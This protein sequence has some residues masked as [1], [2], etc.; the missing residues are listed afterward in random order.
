MTARAA[1]ASSALTGAALP[2]ARMTLFL[3]VMFALGPRLVRFV[4][5]RT[6]ASSDSHST[7][8]TAL[9]VAFLFAFCA[10]YM[11]GM[12][13]ITG[14]YLAGV[15]VAGT[16]SR[17]IIVEPLRSMCNAFF[18]PVFFVSIG[19]QVDA[20]DLGSHVGFFV[21]LLTVAIAGKV[22]GCA[23][24]ALA[25]GFGKRNSMIVGVG[26]IPR[27]EVGLITAS[28]GFAAGLISRG[29]YVQVV[30]LVLATTLITPALLRVAFA[31]PEIS[32]EPALVSLTPESATQEEFVS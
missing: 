10:A 28:L 26:M 6:E 11:G 29:N 5:Q 27:G 15:F 18:G 19:L 2:I 1:H 23:A 16:P 7:P 8:A 3:V 17:K 20:R 12:A 24:G 4:L 25:T 13:A 9:A 22:V 30:V 32:A 21:A 14:S 31:R